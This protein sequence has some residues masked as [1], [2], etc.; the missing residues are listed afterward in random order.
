MNTSLDNTCVHWRWRQLQNRSNALNRRLLNIH[1]SGTHKQMYWKRRDLYYTKQW[2]R[3]VSQ[4]IVNEF[5]HR[6]NKAYR[7]KKNQ[8]F[9]KIARKG[10]MQRNIEHSSTI[11]SGL[12]IHQERKFRKNVKNLFSLG[13]KFSIRY[14]KRDLII[15]TDQ[16]YSGWKQISDATFRGK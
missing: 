14:G 9:R 16:N 1:I 7:S 2:L 4:H 3:I 12:W 10:A 6:R 5:V 8:K 15:I 13:A 11:E